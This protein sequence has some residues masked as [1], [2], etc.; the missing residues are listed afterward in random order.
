MTVLSFPRVTLGNMNAKRLA[1]IATI[2]C[3]TVFPAVSMGV[4]DLVGV[5]GNGHVVERERTVRTFTEIEV[6]GSE[7]LRVHR[8]SACRVIVSCDEN[9]QDLYRVRVSGSRLEMGFEPGVRIGGFTRVVVDVWIDEFE[10]LSLS[11]SGDAS[12]E[13]VFSSRRFDLV[14]SGSG[15]VKGGLSADDMNVK[16]SGSGAVEMR[17]KA[18]SLS[19]AISGSGDFNA[20]DFDSDAVTIVVSGSGKATLGDSDTL[21]VVIS[22]SGD[23]RYEGNPR[24]SST[25]SGS[26]SVRPR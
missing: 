4:A 10:G 8:G 9:L 17:G 2:A 18:D 26:G 7:E 14:V 16:I 13:D 3:A 22:G 25:V 20:D 21:S 23:V 1:C 5:S 6:S 15:S 12:I 11:G 19:V 24:V